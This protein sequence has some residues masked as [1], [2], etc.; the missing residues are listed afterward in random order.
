MTT[1]LLA[2]RPVPPPPE[3]TR[4]RLR[5]MVYE[6]DPG[7]L[8]EA[9]PR[10]LAPGAVV[11]DVPTEA[12]HRAARRALTGTL[13]LALEVLDGRRPA[14]QLAHHFDDAPLRYWRAAA[15]QRRRRTPAR[16]LRMRL[17]L[18]LPGIAE[19]AVVC[20]ID[21]R[22]RAL[23]ARFDRADPTASWRCTEVRLG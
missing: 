15:H 2:P 6:P 20:D 8:A 22:V 12:E 11:V 18:P 21:G 4:P 17:C 10:P 9:P 19:V 1:L 7:T 5:R 23:A 16:A 13:R 14:A 3:R